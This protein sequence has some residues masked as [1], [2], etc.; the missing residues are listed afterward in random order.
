[1]H[2]G[3]SLA[4]PGAGQGVLGGRALMLAF[5]VAGLLAALA[6][7]WT[8]WAI[9]VAL[10]LRVVSALHASERLRKFDEDDENGR[11]PI[12]A[13][14]IGV[15]GIVYFWI[16][17]ERFHIPGSSMMPT[18][19]I[20]DT[21]Y[22]ERITTLWSPPQRGEVIVFMHPCEKTSH[23]K[24]VV[25]V[26]GD[27]VEVR[28]SKLYVNGRAVA[29][30]LV[31]STCTYV[32]HVSN[33]Q[34]YTRECS[35]H[36][37][38]LGGHTFETLQLRDPRASTKDF[39]SL[40]RI[41]RTCTGK[42]PTGKIVET[43]HGATPCEPQLHYVVPAGALFVLGDNRANSSDSRYWGLLPVENVTGRAI[44]VAWPLANAGM[45]H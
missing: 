30:E 32:D 41:E 29:T 28:C 13:S 6:V 42:Q 9:F 22:I 4:F 38:T 8:V 26:A 11:L 15:A 35:R 31:E 34:R 12:Y 5:A 44:G 25:G 19:A 10:G 17:A 1:M 24:R 23:I 40:D 33:D 27:T 37:E 14:V 39:P 21:V 43:K 36:R 18:I 3:W 16:A 2:V 45:V 7:T 20:D